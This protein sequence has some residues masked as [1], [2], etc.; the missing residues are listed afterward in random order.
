MRCILR[1]TAYILTFALVF[2]MMAGTAW[3]APGGADDPLVSLSYL[4][5]IFTDV[6][7]QRLNQEASDA[8]KE[9]N[10]YFD[11]KFDALKAETGSG[12]ATDAVKQAVADK[13]R[14]SGGARLVTLAKGESVTG[15]IGTKMV[16]ISGSAHLFGVQGDVINIT[17]GSLANVG[18]DAPNNMHYLFASNGTSGFSANTDGTQIMV[19]DSYSGARQV[20][21]TKYADAL[22]S[23]GLFKGTN[24]GYDLD[25]KGDRVQGLIMLIR[26]MG[27]EDEALQHSGKTPFTDM[28][29]WLEGHKYIGYAY[30]NGITKGTNTENTLFSPNM[31]LDGKMYVTFVL[32]ALGYD[33]SK[34]DFHWETSSYDL[35]KSVGI[36]TDEDIADINGGGFYRDHVVKISFKALSVELKGENRTLGQKLVADGVFTQDQLNKA[37]QSVQ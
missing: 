3:G 6:F 33:D 12:T 36:L 7:E 26:L 17:R 14:G 37:L 34:G 24:D 21:N 18:T 15:K 4:K 16:V 31:E 1:K 32:R 2:A 19:Y 29:G 8:S 10:A 13:I 30:D 28:T 27:K 22:F 20:Q 35:A 25:K 9:V 23:L 5:T 11:G